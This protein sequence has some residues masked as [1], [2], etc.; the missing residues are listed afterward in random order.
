MHNQDKISEIALEFIILRVLFGIQPK[1]HRCD[2]L[3]MEIS[4]KE[5]K[6]F[7]GLHH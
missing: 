5:V 2:I 6:D 1:C 3:V 4:G 7:G